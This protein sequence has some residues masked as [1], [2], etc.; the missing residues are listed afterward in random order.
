[1]SAHDANL[2]DAAANPG[3]A[4]VADLRAIRAAS[5]AYTEIAPRVRDLVYDSYLRTQGVPDGLSSYGRIIDYVVAV[6]KARPELL[7]GS[8]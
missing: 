6:R 4:T 3:G 2:A 8:R 5:D 1:M 7:G